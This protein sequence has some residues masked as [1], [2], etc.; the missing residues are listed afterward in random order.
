M[1][2]VDKETLETMQ[3]S[4]WRPLHRTLREE[5]WQQLGHT[6]SVF[7]NTWPKHDEEAHM[8]DDENGDCRTDQR[9]DQG[10][11]QLFQWTFPRTDAIAKGKEALGD[12]LSGT[13]VKEIYVPKK[14][15]NIV[16]KP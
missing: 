7:N 13:V 4:C 11:H 10:Y 8:K 5:L 15:V 2:A 9:K 3:S 12:R 14:I 6:E 16:V 1:A